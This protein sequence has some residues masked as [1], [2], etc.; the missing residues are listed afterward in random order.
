MNLIKPGAWVLVALLGAGGVLLRAQTFGT[1]TPS[2][3]GTALPGTC[4]VGNFFW[5]T[6]DSTIHGCIATNTWAA[7]IQAGGAI[8]PSATATTT[9]SLLECVLVSAASTNATNCKSTPGNLYGMS[10]INTTA[11]LY[12]LR[13]YNASGTPTCSSATGFIRSVPIPASATGAGLVDNS[14]IGVGYSTGIAF[15]FTGGSS[16]T[17]NTNAATGVFGVLRYK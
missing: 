15:C 7:M 16:S 3:F 4:S 14:L 6:D 2:T 5:K 12:Y 1:P 10:F 9:N 11:T 13:L 17:D 8:I